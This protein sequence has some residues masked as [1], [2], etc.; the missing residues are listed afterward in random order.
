MGLS[1]AELFD[2]LGK[3]YETAFAGLT[4]Q[5][6]EL[7][8]LLGELPAGAR[9]LDLGSGTGRPTAEVLAAAGH[10]VTGIDVSPRMVEI[11]SAQVPAARFEVGDL[12]TL[13]YSSGSWHAIT[14][15]FPLLQMSRAD[16]DDALVRFA[17]WLKPGGIFVMATVPVDIEGVEI[18]FMGK[19]AADVS[20]YPAEVYRRRLADLGLEVVRERI[21]EFR[22]N[23]V[24]TTEPEH[25]LFL[26]A[27]KA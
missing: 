27:R 9:V 23:H 3:D 14:A 6:E 26:A 5:R 21:V 1:A 24:T 8:W 13:T 18:E 25:D 12:R 16:I 2:E 22:P 11:A 10:D 7:D 4:A 15:F 17:D 19:K 20:S